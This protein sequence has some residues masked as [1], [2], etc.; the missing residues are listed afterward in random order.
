MIGL[1][2]NFLIWIGMIVL[3]QFEPE[4]GAIALIVLWPIVAVL[5]FFRNLKVLPFV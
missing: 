1:I 2:V 5:W 4:P 3:Y